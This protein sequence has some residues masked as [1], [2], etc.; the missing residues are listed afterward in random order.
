MARINTPLQQS[1]AVFKARRLTLFGS[2][3][4]LG[5]AVL[6][7]GPGGTSTMPAWSSS[8]QAAE[9]MQQQPAGFADLVAKV[10]PAVISVRVTMNAA[11]KSSDDNRN[12][13]TFPF[14][15]GSP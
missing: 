7:A 14:R 8:A 2:V 11:M 12:D 6:F 10:K 13:N 1:R 3:A 5:I 9:T 15:S 4:A